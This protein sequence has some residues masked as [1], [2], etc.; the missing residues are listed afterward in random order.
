M[1][2]FDEACAVISRL[3][4]PLGTEEVRLDEADGRILAA[5]VTAASAA[6]AFA[7]SAMDG[8]AVRDGDLGSGGAALRVVGESFAGPLSFRGVLEPRC[9]VRI[10]T[11]AA[12]PEGADRVVVQEVVRRDGD[13]AMIP[14]PTGGR[15]IRAAGSDFAA[16]EVLLDRGP[17]PPPTGPPSRCSAAPA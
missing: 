10:F 3:A 8:Y 7:V 5:P 15:H 4:G 9:C 12:L 14:A 16:G 6:P 17:R 11:G 1:N 2:S 13:M